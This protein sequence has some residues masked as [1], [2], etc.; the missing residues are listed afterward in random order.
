MKKYINTPRI[1]GACVE[2]R[3]RNL[4][5]MKKTERNAHLDNIL[6]MIHMDEIAG[7]NISVRYHTQCYALRI[8][9]LECGIWFSED[10]AG[11]FGPV[12][13]E[14]IISCYWDANANSIEEFLNEAENLKDKAQRVTS[15]L[16]DFIQ[17]IEALRGDEFVKEPILS[18]TAV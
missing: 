8:D 10:S 2:I 12:E 7:K 11:V 16:L 3:R 5:G 18:K 13:T 1:K 17:M 15:I 4:Q 6:S 9:T 14:P